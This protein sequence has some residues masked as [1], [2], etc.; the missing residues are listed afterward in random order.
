MDKLREY[1]KLKR[2]SLANSTIVTYSSI[3]FNVF[4]NVFQKD[5]FSIDKLNNEAEK[6]IQSLAELKPSSRKT[7][8]SALYILTDNETYKNHMMDDIQCYKKDVQKQSMTDE[9]K[10]NWVSEN[11]INELLQE[12]KTKANFLFKKKILSINDLQEIQDYI[13][14]LLYSG[15]I[16]VRRSKDYV[17][18]KIKNIDKVNNNFMERNKFIFNVYKTAKFYGKQEIELPLSFKKTILQWIKINPTE[19]LLFDSNKNKLNSVKINHR[20][21]KIFGKD[22]GS[23][24]NMLR[25]AFLSNKYKHTI[26]TN[27][28][29][30]NDLANMGSSMGQSTT[31]IK[32]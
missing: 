14:L 4:K 13:I 11:K 23:G 18:F 5:I 9:D 19:Y 29:L 10:S 32:Q 3:I 6:V 20:L 8:L 26:D 21:N 27:K 7:K 12:L 31:Y 25:H 1:I 16:S 28:E 22:K 24:T 17:D 30:A 2:P 15:I